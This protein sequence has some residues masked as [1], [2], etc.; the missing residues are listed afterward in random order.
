M[1]ITTLHINLYKSIKQPIS[2]SALP[3]NI[4]IGQ[5]NCG[6]SNILYAIDYLFDVQGVSPILEYPGAD[7]EVELVFTEE[8]LD[9]WNL[10][11]KTASLTIKDEKR[12][13][14]FSN[15]IVNY[16]GNWKDLL[17]VKIKHLN[18][19]AF[20]DLEAVDKIGRASC[21]ERV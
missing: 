3:V 20:N 7:I 4:L 17:S 9:R 21:R 6:K 13:L 14:A 5:N 16:N 1:K 10:P 15:Q 12:K 18:Y 8:E 2:F 19:D 11:S